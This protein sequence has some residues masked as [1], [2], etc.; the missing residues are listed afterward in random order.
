VWGNVAPLGND[1]IRHGGIAFVRVAGQQ[2][3][4]LLAAE[5]QLLRFLFLP[6]VRP[7]LGFLGRAWQDWVSVAIWDAA[8]PDGPR[9]NG[10]CSM[11]VR[12]R[13]NAR[14]IG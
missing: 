6:V 8:I 12:R 7:G 10:S 11:S 3:E 1:V 14:S 5:S 4:Q 13:L 2:V 9:A